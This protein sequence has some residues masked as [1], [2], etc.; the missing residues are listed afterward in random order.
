MKGRLDGNAILVPEPFGS[1]LHKRHLV[2][3]LG[4]G[5]LRLSFVE[6]AWCML[7]ERLDVDGVPT[8]GDLLARAAGQAEADYLVYADLR[9]RGLVVRHAGATLAVGPRGSELG[10][11]PAYTV[12]AFSER[13]PI[14]AADL[15]ASVDSVLALVDDDGAVTHYRLEASEPQGG[16]PLGTL[17]PAVGTLLRDR[18]LIEEGSVREAWL[19]EGIGV[20]HGKGLVLS[21]VEA[22]HLRRRGVLR[23]PAGRTEANPAG[24]ELLV[25]VH[26]AVRSR[27][28]LCKSGFKFGTHFRAYRGNPDE[29]HAEWLIETVAPDATLAWSDL[30]RAIRLAH[31]V[32]KKFLL[33]VV[34][35]EV[36]FLEFAWF[37]P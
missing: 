35:R 36:Q 4:P 34:G 8:V 16:Q 20:P 21:L 2:G 32:R 22:E 9:E 33:A 11:A 31:G 18:V 6:A 1:R 24:F 12:R 37:R 15:A 13:T 10:A 17:P 3:E 27:G 30:S 5:G 23:F 19:R 7:G 26:E 14:V 25:T 28:A 29:T